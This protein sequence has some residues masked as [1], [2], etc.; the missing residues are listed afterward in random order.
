[1]KYNGSSENHQIKNL[2]CI[3]LCTKY[4]ADN[5]KFYDLT[6]KDEIILFLNTKIISV[7][8]SLS[9]LVII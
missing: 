3:I 1:M 6:E 2:K 8:S 4:L 9:K 7:R 5:I